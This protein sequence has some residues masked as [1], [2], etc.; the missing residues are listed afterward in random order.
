MTRIS[1]RIL[2]FIL[3]AIAFISL[4]CGVVFT[5]PRVKM[6]KAA[7]TAITFTSATLSDASDATH[8]TSIRFDTSGLQWQG[9]HNWVS[10][11][12]DAWKSIADH[13]TV[14]GRTVTEINDATTSDQ[15]ITIMMQPAGSFSF[16]R[17]YIP[18]EIMDVSEVKSMGI[19]DGWSFTDT[20]A[21]TS[22]GV[23]N[24][25]YNTTFTASAATFYH[26]GGNTMTPESSY[27]SATKLTASD[28]TISEARLTL[29]QDSYEVDIDI[30]M[31][32]YSGDQYDPM[33]SSYDAVRHSIY[34]NGKSIEEWN[35]QKIAEDAR[36]NDPAMYSRFPQNSQDAGHKNIF[37]K[38]VSLVGTET[39]FKLY[40]FQELVADCTNVTVQVG[41]GCTYG[42]KYM[43]TENTEKKVVLTQS[44]VDI[45][46]WLTFLDN[47]KD[48]PADWGDTNLYYIHTNNNAAW[49][50][51]YPY[52]S[53]L[54]QGDPSGAAG[55]QTQLKYIYFNDKS[56][57]QI[58]KEDDNTYGSTE[59]HIADTA[60][61]QNAPIF[62]HL[63]EEVGASLKII[64]SETYANGVRDRIVIKKG[65]NIK[66]NNTSYYVSADV[67]FDYQDG[68]WIKSI[69]T[70]IETTVTD[71]Q[72]FFDGATS[73]VGIAV[74]GSQYA[75]A[76]DTYMGTVQLAKTYSQSESFYKYILI[77]DKPMTASGEGFLNV[78]GHMGYFSFRPMVNG[79]RNDA[80]TKITVLAG[81]HLPT[82]NALLTGAKEVYVTTKDVT[83]VKGGD[84]TWTKYEID[85][86]S[87]ITFGDQGQL[88]EAT[89]TYLIRTKNN[90]WTTY[91]NL[92]TSNPEALKYIYFNG[93]SLYDINANDDESYG[94][95]FDTITSNAA[96]A[97]ISVSY[98]SDGGNYSFIQIW[99]PTGYPNMGASADENHKSIEI[100]AGLS[101]TEGGSTWTIN[102]DLK[103]VNVDGKW[104]SAD[105]LLDASTVTIADPVT[106]G[107][108]GELLKV[109]ITSSAW[110]FNRNSNL[111]Y[112][113]FSF[114]ALREKIFINGVSLHEINT[115]VDDSK[116]SYATDPQ[117][118]ANMAQWEGGTY[119]LFANPTY[120]RGSG[121]TLSV[122]IHQDYINSLSAGSITL[123][124][125]AGFTGYKGD[126]ADEKKETWTWALPLSDNVSKLI[127][128]NVK[129]GTKE[130]TL[131]NILYQ[132][133]SANYWLVFCLNEHDY[134][135]TQDWEESKAFDADVKDAMLKNDLIRIG[136]YKNIVLK[137]NIV[138]SRTVN[139]TLQVTT[140]TE[141]T[142]LDFYNQCKNFGDGPYIDIWGKEGTIAVRIVGGY[143][144]TSSGNY[145]RSTITEVIIQEGCAFPSYKYLMGQTTEYD[146]YVVKEET[147]F[148]DVV[149]GDDNYYINEFWSKF[150][151]QMADGAAVRY[152]ANEETRGI[153]FET[154]ISKTD[155]EVLRGLLKN[156]TYG[157]ISFGTLIVPT[158][159]LMGGQFTHEWL[160][161]N[162]GAAGTGYLDIISSAMIDPNNP[163]NDVWAEKA[164]TKDYYGFYG[165]I[166]KLNESN[167]GRAFSGLGYIALYESEDDE[168]PVEYVYAPYVSA[169]S[170]S[171]SF[172]ANAAVNDLS[173]TQTG[174]YKY[175]V[176]GY[177][178][179]YTAAAHT[180][181]KNYLVMSAESIVASQD[182][183]TALDKPAG[184]YTVNVN[185][186]LDG[187]YV[188]L[189]YTT[190]VNVRG[191]FYY[192]S[193]DGSKVA[194]DTEGNNWEEF[195]LQAG[196]SEH[197][198]LLDIFRSNGAGYGIEAD[199][200][201]LTK[202]V[203]ENAELSTGKTTGGSVKLIG[204][205]SSMKTIDTAKQEIYV[206]KGG[207][208]VG[209][210][211]GLGGALTYLAKGGLYEGVKSGNVV[212]SNSNTGFTTSYGSTS[213]LPE[214]GAVNLINNFDA[215]RQIQQSWYANVGGD[216]GIATTVT[217]SYKYNLQYDKKYSWSTTYLT[218]SPTKPSN[219]GANG[220]NRAV[221]TTGATT[222]QPSQYWPYNP[223]QAGDC[224]SNPGQIVDYEVNAEKGYIYV[225]AR[226]MDWAKGQGSDKLAGTVAGGV[227]TKSYM[228][229]Y[230][231]LDD[232][233]T[234]IVNNSFVDWNGF[235]DMEACDFTSIELPAFYTIQ[236]LNYYVSYVG[237]NAWANEALTFNN[238]MDSWVGNAYYQSNVH[239]DMDRIAEEWFAWASGN[240]ASSYAIGV[241]I[242]NVAQYTSGRS[243]TSNAQN[244]VVGEY[245]LN[246]NA[247]SNILD[248]LGLMS[249]MQTISYSY[250]GAYVQNTSYT[251]PGM[252][253]RM[254]AYT[255]IEYSY[256]VC[257]DTVANIRNTFKGIAASGRITNAGRE[258]Y[259]EKIGLDAW[260]REDKK[261]TW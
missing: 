207:V 153:R 85:I 260:A 121:T 252:R 248:K 1:K 42:S 18:A 146:R 232:N 156:G 76:P 202:V 6:A 195:Y 10:A 123:T 38:P 94:S 64:V 194:T 55:G 246:N 104:M 126:D 66:Q 233:G 30:G 173:S 22:G 59:S 134:P 196:T 187:P 3:S 90:Y 175:L 82:Y 60:N 50:S 236:S 212:V 108:Y 245:S 68:K 106:A 131:Q 26:V 100:K 170:R 257:V 167:Y 204:L 84:G 105:Q 143:Q 197:K 11:S 83:F 254:L 23:V 86:T 14:N 28:I 70:E 132:D 21:T 92:N 218:T 41:Q 79:V 162:Y 256:A 229:N 130:T 203:F 176:N 186:L 117:T 95:K 101:I 241:Y 261:W 193:S 133:S 111:D 56:I 240:T 24:P 118:L 155:V 166:V 190:N 75:S 31:K 139:D 183:G 165:S 34:I 168:E 2:T 127:A 32:V 43:V 37:V 178:S 93:E 235:T 180:N 113:Y 188:Q 200:I 73:F 215:G 71:V 216:N 158:D 253:A 4:A 48:A 109:D 52:Y 125:A 102:E 152:S 238:E 110:N 179:P 98:G 251:A 201:Y 141:I 67:A 13:T 9:Y 148:V 226:A 138:M 116:Y 259:Y 17:L 69:G 214:S 243:C 198:Q 145:C 157:K 171:A 223:V 119:E 140:A 228:E 33:Q 97:P 62:V 237:E 39:G 239:S 255:P 89:E 174:E 142:L 99:V 20:K 80:A 164:T 150:D 163:D 208:T 45:T 53:S 58:N 129:M 217:D 65:F 250:Q 96:C 189:N 185:K 231:R 87:E 160:M 51:E 7:N 72:L 192:Q 63:S 219:Y 210:H 19:L 77:D 222:E 159:Y 147:L 81:C 154:R 91:G 57:Y 182:F 135:S 47:T 15:K 209:A 249:N 103:W 181:L 149:E 5:A 172:V 115:T 74:E 78:W 128:T 244:A 177:Y 46:D 220:Y 191:K 137:G 247:S 12:A 136:F 184:T 205:Y 114:V 230:Y 61:P 25:T 258:G 54:N 36:F 206:T 29:P 49:T 225:K 120:L 122:Y 211:L 234:L 44:V 199:D 107:T 242:P 227:T 169:N 221:C 224:V 161:N 27:S 40:I 213:S 8:G 124:V 88:E 112:N 35:A 16:L 151:I 144:D